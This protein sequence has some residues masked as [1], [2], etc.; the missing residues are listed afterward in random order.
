MGDED[1][2]AASLVDDEL[3]LP[4]QRVSHAPPKND[5]FGRRKRSPEDFLPELAVRQFGLEAA[6]QFGSECL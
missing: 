4:D 3:D 2:T 6:A 1:G 5:R